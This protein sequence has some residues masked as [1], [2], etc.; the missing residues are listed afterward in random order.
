MSLVRKK[1]AG[2]LMMLTFAPTLRIPRLLR[3]RR[4]GPL[5][6]SGILPWP[7]FNKWQQTGVARCFGLTRVRAPVVGDITMVVGERPLQF[8]LIAIMSQHAAAMPLCSHAWE[9]YAALL[10]YSC[11]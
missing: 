2:H 5:R 8:R 7:P 6:E 9:T 4:Q 1:N 10:Q 11:L 3:L